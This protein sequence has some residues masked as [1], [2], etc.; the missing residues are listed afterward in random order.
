MNLAGCHEQIGK[1][2][3]A[4]SEY[5]EL[6]GKAAAAK[7]TDR[8]QLAREHWQALEPR[9][10]HLSIVILPSVWLPKMSIEV[11]GVQVPASVLE[12][13]GGTGIART[14]SVKVDPGTHTVVARAPGKR[15][16]VAK[17]VVDAPRETVTV[18]VLAL[19][20]APVSEKPPSVAL[21]QAER[22]ATSRSQRTAGLVVGGV[23]VAALLTGG[24]FGILAAAQAS[25]V[26][27][28]TGPAGCTG[29]RLQEAQNAHN[30]ANTFANVANVL[31]PVGAIFGGV[32]AALFFTA[33]GDETKR[34][35]RVSPTL[36]PGLLGVSASGAF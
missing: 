18:Q 4:W 35:A 22:V 6:E 5:K 33:K 20:D 1:F 17:A 15:D 12:G 21:D 19:R 8:V 2:A 7:R 36:A 29:A 27:E 34:S 26:A 3:S 28:C 10:S 23:G 14:A 32:G 25:N 31:V 11:D 13:E 30:R 16:F 24:V 9:L